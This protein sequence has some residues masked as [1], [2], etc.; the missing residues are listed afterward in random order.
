[1]VVGGGGGGG[2]IRPTPRKHIQEKPGKDRVAL[3]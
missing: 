3:C 1:M 2:G